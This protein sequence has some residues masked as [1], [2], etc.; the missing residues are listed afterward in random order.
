MTEKSYVNK[1]KILHEDANPQVLVVTP[2]WS[3]HKVSKETKKTIR[4]NDIPIIWVS[5]EGPNNIPMNAKLGIKWAMNHGKDRAHWNPPYYLMIDRDISLGRHMIDRM[6]KTLGDAQEKEW[7][8][9]I[10]FTYANFKFQ[11]E[12]NR[13]FPAKPYDINDLMQ[14]NY[15]SSNSMFMLSVVNEIGL[16]TD[17]HFKRLLDW[18]F[19]L[20]LY[21][22]GYLGIPCTSANFVATSTKNDISAGSPEDYHHKRM[23][24]L[25]YFIKPILED[26]K[27]KYAEE[28]EDGPK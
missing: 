1:V 15:I 19:I 8:M 17:D 16:V 2:L 6:A 11:G 13:D 20:K 27:S 23:R 9:P 22:H 24:V 14:H 18:C 12:M 10:A 4:R 28:R 3:G 25:E 21:Y 26:V 7:N 5:S